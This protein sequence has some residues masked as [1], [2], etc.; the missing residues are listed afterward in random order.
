MMERMM[1]RMMVGRWRVGGGKGMELE[2][3]EEESEREL[4]SNMCV[5]LFAF[6]HVTFLIS[7]NEDYKVFIIYTYISL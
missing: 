2:R 1:G 5:G 6:L 7:A 3:V 4:L